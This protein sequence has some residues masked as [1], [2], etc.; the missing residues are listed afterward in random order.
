[1]AKLLQ[2][3]LDTDVAAVRDKPMRW[4]SEQ[5]FFRDPNRPVFSDNAYF[6]PPADGII[7]YAKE[8]EADEATVTDQAVVDATKTGFTRTMFAR[9]RYLPDL[10]SPNRNRQQMAQRM[11]L[12]APIQGTAADII[13]RAMIRMEDALAAARLRAAGLERLCFSLASRDSFR[14]A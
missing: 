6:Y 1:M 14:L 12:N 9:R 13:R 7:L 8:V 3:W 10:L 11:A 2:E 5:Y 4:I